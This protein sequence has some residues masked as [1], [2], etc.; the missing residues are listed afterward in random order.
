MKPLPWKC[1]SHISA[2]IRVSE[3]GCW[4]WQGSCGQ[5]GY[6]TITYQNESWYVHRMA[7]ELYKGPIPPGVCVCHHCDNRKCVNPAHLWVGTKAENNAD[8][9]K[10]GR[11]RSF[12]LVR[13]EDCP[14]AKLTWA[15]VD[16]IRRI[17]KC[18]AATQRT[19]AHQFGVSHST[20][21]NVLREKTW[22]RQ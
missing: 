7:Y 2:R 6:A 12:G 17:G 11:G 9:F 16:E 3:T 8:M 10:K 19:L 22:G 13:G 18:G 20:I 1:L 4:E 14:N 5:N 21:G 15:D